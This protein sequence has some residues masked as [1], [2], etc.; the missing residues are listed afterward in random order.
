V[1]APTREDLDQ[2]LRYAEENI[3]LGDEAADQAER[4]GRYKQAEQALASAS[5]IMDA[6]TA[7][8]TPP[9]APGAWGMPW[10]MA[11]IPRRATCCPARRP[12]KTGGQGVTVTPAMASL[13]SQRPFPRN[14]KP[15]STTPM[16]TATASTRRAAHMT[17]FARS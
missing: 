17:A 6:I 13:F 8:I 10:L 2:A 4:H 1:N 16:M 9:L 14:H 11:V 7:A 5:R 3:R 15:T 12:G